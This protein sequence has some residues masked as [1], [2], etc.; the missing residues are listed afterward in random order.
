LELLVSL[1]NLPKSERLTKIGI[2]SDREMEKL[3]WTIAAHIR[4][5]AVVGRFPW[6]FVQ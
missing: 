5:D 6:I 4:A 3:R 1:A 2:S